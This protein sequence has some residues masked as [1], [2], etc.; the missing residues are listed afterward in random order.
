MVVPGNGAGAKV[1]RF[2]A[3]LIL[4]TVLNLHLVAVLILAR[5][6][7]KKDAAIEMLAVADALQ[8]EDEIVELLLG[9]Q[10]AGAIF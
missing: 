6:R 7:P 9:L 1:G 2:G 3:I 4:E 5:N 10:V 8:L